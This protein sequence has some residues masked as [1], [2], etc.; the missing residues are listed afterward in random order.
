MQLRAKLRLELACRLQNIGSTGP[1]ID[2]AYD[3]TIF[4]VAGGCL[5][6][7]C[8]GPHGTVSVMQDGGSYG[9]KQQLPE[10]GVPARRHHDEGRIQTFGR[11]DDALGRV[12]KVYPI[13]KWRGLRLPDTELNQ[14]LLGSV[15]CRFYRRFNLIAIFHA[16]QHMKKRNRHVQTRR[17]PNDRWPEISGAAGKVDGIENVLDRQH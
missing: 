11:A 10:T 1:H 4:V 15:A 12:S 3:G 6:G 7:M 16:V 8:L 2:C 9:A 14:G 17:H 13:A 5:V